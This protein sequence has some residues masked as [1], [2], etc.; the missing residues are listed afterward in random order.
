MLPSRKEDIE[1]LAKVLRHQVYDQRRSFWPDREPRGLE[2][3]DPEIAAQALGIHF[4]YLQAIAFDIPGTSERSEIAGLIDR[5]KGTIVVAQRFG[6]EVMRFTAAH[7]LGHWQLHETEVIQHRD[8]P[9]IGLER[10]TRDPLEREADYFAACFLMPRGYVTQQFKL[11]FPSDGPF[12]CDDAAVH[13]LRV[14]SRDSLLYPQANSL[15][16][17]KIL[18]RAKS[19]GGQPFEPL[20]ALFKVSIETMAIRI[21]ELGLVRA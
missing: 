1:H 15:V 20:A 11:R 13:H 6:L 19:Y 9:I 5:R 21:K 4:Q 7:E 16:R 17:E 14:Y 10:E 3:A 8:L 18:A 2:I 12:V